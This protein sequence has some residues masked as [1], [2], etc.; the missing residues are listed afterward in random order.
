MHLSN[1]GCKMLLLHV[2]DPTLWV[3]REVCNSP[4]I[5][6]LIPLE[7]ECVVCVVLPCLLEVP[8]EPVRKL[9]LYQENLF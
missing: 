1:A 6:A 3:M 9:P 5:G 7:C 4:R 2:H 8:F